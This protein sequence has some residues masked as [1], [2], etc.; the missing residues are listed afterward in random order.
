MHL[1]STLAFF[2]FLV[3]RPVPVHVELTAAAGGVGLRGLR[4]NQRVRGLYSGSFLIFSFSVS[5]SSRAIT[6]ECA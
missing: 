5:L 4:E 2:K 1:R 3:R 6:R